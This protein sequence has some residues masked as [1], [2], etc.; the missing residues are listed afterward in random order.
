MTRPNSIIM[1]NPLLHDEIMS[2]Y[3]KNH[4]DTLRMHHQKRFGN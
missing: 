3:L 1:A 2:E 4:E